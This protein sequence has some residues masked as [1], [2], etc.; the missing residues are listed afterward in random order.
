[1]AAC[2]VAALVPTAMAGLWARSVLVD[3]AEHEHQRRVAS[4]VVSARERIA[5]RLREDQRA[6]QQLCRRDARLQ[7]AAAALTTPEGRKPSGDWNEEAAAIRGL[8]GMDRLE[9]RVAQAPGRRPGELLGAS[10]GPPLERSS[11]PDLTAALQGGEALVVRTPSPEGDDGQRALLQA[12]SWQRDDVHLAVLGMRTLD[13][14]FVRELLGDLTP[15]HLQPASSATLRPGKGGRHTV[16][17]FEDAGGAPAVHV[18][19][20]LEGASLSE[21]L[22]RLDR[23]FAVAGATGVIFALVLGALLAFTTTRPLRELEQAAVRVG[24]G[25]LE[26]TIGEVHGGE[27]GNALEAFNRMTREI[28]KTRARLLRAERIAAWRD[29]ARRIAHE[30][31]NPLS[32]IQMSIETMRK[33]YAQRHPDFDE[34]F[35]ESTRAILEEVERLERIVSEFSRFARMPRPRAEPVDVAE[36]AA[37]VVGLHR[38]EDTHVGLEV[39][40][41]PP[42][43]ADREQITQVLTNLIQNGLDACRAHH[44]GNGGRVHVWV[45]PSERGRGTDVIVDDDGPGIPPAERG[46]VFEPY[47]T[48]KAGGTGLGLAIVHRI[49]LDHG[50]DIEVDTSPAGGARFRFSLPPEGPPP[51]ADASLTDGSEP[52]APRRD[53]GA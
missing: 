29:I 18:L 38:D 21:Q 40:P 10:P 8:L 17:T 4:V 11:M 16:H 45:G 35:E 41:T 26:S 36:V 25:D 23:G 42:V 13:R 34:I 49:V 46:Q 22:A 24:R 51:E 12:C 31:K 44:G 53:T 39:Q 50:G 37:H 52:H 30:V 14:A 28:K 3:L 43:Q 33:T 5:H 19:A 48:T 9:V 20:Q 15:V 47:H 7:A 32:P 2:T 1:M 27:V 6:L